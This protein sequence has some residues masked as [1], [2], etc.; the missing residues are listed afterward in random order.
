MLNLNDSLYTLEA[1][2]RALLGHGYVIRPI[3]R[4]VLGHEGDEVMIEVPENN[5]KLLIT[6]SQ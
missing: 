2:Q 3:Y 1:Y 4:K 5:H 6:Q